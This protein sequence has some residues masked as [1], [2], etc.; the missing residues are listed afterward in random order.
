[1]QDLAVH[2]V[3]SVPVPGSVTAYW[4]RTIKNID[5]NKQSSR[6]LVGVVKTIL[7]K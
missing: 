4:V 3:F 1:M 2:Y 6:M 5:D 7:L